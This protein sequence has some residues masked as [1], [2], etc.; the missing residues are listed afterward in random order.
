MHALHLN[1]LVCCQPC[2]Y[3]RSPI[4]ILR[5]LKSTRT[6]KSTAAHMAHCGY[7]YSLFSEVLYGSVPL[8]REIIQG[9]YPAYLTEMYQ[10]VV[11]TDAYQG[12]LGF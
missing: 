12:L 9:H 5:Y 4:R 2:T 8:F 11:F 10:A 7:K 1:F 3:Q 6:L